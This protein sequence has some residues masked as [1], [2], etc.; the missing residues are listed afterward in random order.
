[1]LVFFIF[2]YVVVL[3]YIY[4][5]FFF[6]LYHRYCKASHG[7]VHEYTLCLQVWVLVFFIFLYAVVFFYIYTVFFFLNI[8]F[9]RHLSFLSLNI[10]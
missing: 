5:V 10:G 9:C 2:L 4:T 6:F 8:Y 1:V 3:F 7:G